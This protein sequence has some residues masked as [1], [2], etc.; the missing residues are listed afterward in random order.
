M[1]ESNKMK[2]NIG[3]KGGYSY[4]FSESHSL[5]SFLENLCRLKRYTSGF[6]EIFKGPMRMSS[7]VLG[8]WQAHNT[9]QPPLCGISPP[10]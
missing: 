6:S 8:Q 5:L 7:V 1:Q 3:C 4:R 10:V 2:V 9:R